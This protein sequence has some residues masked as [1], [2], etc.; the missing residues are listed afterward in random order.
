MG[1]G[2]EDILSLLQ[3][4]EIRR[5]N[6]QEVEMA[7]SNLTLPGELLPSTPVNLANYGMIGWLVLMRHRGKT[8]G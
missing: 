4:K 5:E 2:E 8:V 7:F 6:A 3:D 1:T